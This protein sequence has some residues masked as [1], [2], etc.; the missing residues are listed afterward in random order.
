MVA[1]CENVFKALFMSRAPRIDTLHASHAG[2]GVC[3]VASATAR[4]GN[5]CQWACAAFVNAHLRVGKPSLEGYRTEAA[6][7]TS[8]DDCC[9]HGLLGYKVLGSV[10]SV[11]TELAILKILSG[12]LILADYCKTVA[13]GKDDA[14]DPVVCC[15]VVVEGTDALRLSVAL[16][17][18]VYDMAVPKSVVGKDERTR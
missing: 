9:S 7:G 12:L 6:G 18:R 17:L 10:F 14:C 2:E 4:Y 1:L 8:S 13:Q 15:N 5:L 16:V 11:L 3:E